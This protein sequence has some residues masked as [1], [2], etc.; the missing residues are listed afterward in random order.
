MQQLGGQQ[1]Q[2]QQVLDGSFDGVAEV[3]V[4]QLDPASRDMLLVRQQQQQIF[5]TSFNSVVAVSLTQLDPASR[6]SFVR[7]GVLAEGAVV[8][9]DMLSSL[10]EQVTVITLS[11]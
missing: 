2:Q 9:K 6:D 8:P 1:Q 3:S 10:W 4:D 5:D 7:L 11:T